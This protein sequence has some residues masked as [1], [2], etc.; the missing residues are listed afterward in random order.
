MIAKL[1]TAGGRGDCDLVFVVI[2][3]G[4][5]GS[6]GARQAMPCLPVAERSSD[7]WTTFPMRA[8]E[9]EVSWLLLHFF[10]EQT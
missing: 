6:A 4:V 7:P 10:S 1:G 5:S 9:N 3:K 2:R 8:R